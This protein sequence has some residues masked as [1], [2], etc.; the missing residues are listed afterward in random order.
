MSR[1][2]QE[3]FFFNQAISVS[4]IG[5]QSLLLVQSKLQKSSASFKSAVRRAANKSKKASTEGGPPP[6]SN[7]THGDPAEGDSQM[8]AGHV[9]SVIRDLEGKRAETRDVSGVGS[10]SIKPA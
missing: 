4:L 3:K 7:P 5:C 10:C 6:A 9:R 2:T 1:Q 8:G